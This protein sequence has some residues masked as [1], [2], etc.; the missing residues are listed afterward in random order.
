MGSSTGDNQADKEWN[1]GRE[2]ALNPQTRFAAGQ[3]AESQNNVQ[4]ARMQYAQA[5]LI[6]PKHVPSLYRMGIVL[7]KQKE[8]NRSRPCSRQ[9]RSSSH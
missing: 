6:E 5:L 1:S 3:L 9:S 8:S 7:T 2:P 4:I